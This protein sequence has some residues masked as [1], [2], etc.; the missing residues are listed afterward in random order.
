MRQLRPTSSAAQWTGHNA[1]MHLMDRTDTPMLR[2]R[3]EDLVRAPVEVLREIASFA[4]L[5]A[6]DGAL[7]FLGGDD[8]GRW[9]QL[10]PAHTVS[11][12]GLRFSTGRIA[13][14]PDERWQTAMPP[15][16]RHVVT[17]ATLPLLAR[18]GYVR[19]TDRGPVRVASGS[20]GPD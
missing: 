5:G 7:Q 11:G 1:L 14:R 9:A 19:L 18:Y 8:A 10:R 17:A 16:H 15:A 4:G 2:V 6:E 20:P 12:H 13:I 3:Y